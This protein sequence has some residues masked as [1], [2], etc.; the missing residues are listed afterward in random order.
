MYKTF[1]MFPPIAAHCRPLLHGGFSQGRY[2]LKSA[3]IA[4][5]CSPIFHGSFSRDGDGVIPQKSSHCSP[6]LHCGFSQG[7]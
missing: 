4:T 3:L 7:R 2:F 6:I 5:H 1:Y